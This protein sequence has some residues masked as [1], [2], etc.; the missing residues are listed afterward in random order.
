MKNEKG[1]SLVEVL[2]I[3]VVLAI[4][5]SIVVPRVLVSIDNV[6]KETFRKSANSIVDTV[7]LEYSQMYKKITEPLKYSFLNGDYEENSPKL[8]LKGDLPSIGDVYLSVDGKIALAVVSN[9][10]KYCAKKGLEDS[11]VTIEDYI[12]GKC[13]LNISDDIVIGENYIIDIIVKDENVWTNDSKQVTI[14]SSSKEETKIKY[15]Y[16]TENKIDNSN[17]KDYTGE[18]IVKQN[19]TVYAKLVNK[20]DDDLIS[21]SKKVTRIDKTQPECNFS[22]KGTKGSNDY[23]TSDTVE[24]IMNSSDKGGSGVNTKLTKIDNT[25]GNSLTIKDD[26]ITEVSGTVYD[27]AGN[28]NRCTT[29]IKKDSV[30]PQCDIQIVSG[31]EG[32][33]PWYKSNVSLKVV[34]NSGKSK[35]KNI[36]ISTSSTVNFNAQNLTIV[37]DGKTTVYGYVQNEAGKTGRCTATIQKDSTPPTCLCL[38]ESTTWTKNNRKITTQCNDSTS[39]CVTSSFYNIF[40]KT[41]KTGSV[42]HTIS[43][44]A[45]NTTNCSKTANVYVDKTKPTLGS[46]TFTNLAQASYKMTITGSDN[47]SGV[48]NYSYSVKGGNS[49]SNTTS[50]SFSANKVDQITVKI[51]DKAGNSNSKNYTLN[52]IDAYIRQLYRGIRGDEPEASGLNFWKTEYKNFLKV[53]GGKS[54]NDIVLGIYTSSEATSNLNT[55]TKFVNAVYTGVLGRNADAVGLDS[56]VDKLKN[57]TSRK[58]VLNQ[59]MSTTEFKA[60]V[61][62]YNFAESVSYTPSTY[63]ATANYTCP[64]YWSFDGVKTCSTTESYVCAVPCQVW[65]TRW[66]LIDSGKLSVMHWCPDNDKE[67][68]PYGSSIKWGGCTGYNCGNMGTPFSTC[69]YKYK[70]V[71]YLVNTTCNST[72]ERTLTQDVSI[73]FSCGDNATLKITGDGNGVCYYCPKGGNYNSSTNKCVIE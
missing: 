39:G 44:N 24:L 56:F 26:G 38:G 3:V 49:K 36:G 40:N 30:T 4:I 42:S 23:Y 37:N 11:E 67:I 48:A 59:I 9:D 22:I 55:N 58:D 2:T 13:K 28:S 50:T 20:I 19:G 64:D 5:M 27:I 33:D 68:K 34:G 25:D 15:Q 69:Q 57:G 73:T 12:V 54:I 71:S 72:C 65:Q 47:H 43:D 21:D 62:F 51:L 70:K 32:N 35:V 6:R 52:A 41:T 31:T 14:T 8:K 18:F 29:T 1:F 46:A 45:G 10:K 66:D 16:S 53:N 63:N 7:K 17:W 60:L 61:K